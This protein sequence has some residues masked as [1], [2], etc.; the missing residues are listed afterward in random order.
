M[1]LNLSEWFERYA[2][3]GVLRCLTLKGKEEDGMSSGELLVIKAGL[4]TK[5]RSGM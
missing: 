5:C 1:S 2:I 4:E 3:E